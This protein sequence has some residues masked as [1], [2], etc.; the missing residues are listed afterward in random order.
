[1]QL[2]R[3]LRELWQL[4]TGVAIS[5]LLA[6][7][8]GLSSVAE[9]GL[10]PPSV[11][12]RAEEMAAASTRLLVDAP[13]SSVL[14]LSVSL[15]DVESTT[16]RA[17][18]VSNVMASAPVREYIARRAKVPAEVLEIASPV[19]PEWPRPLAQTG[20]EKHTSD[21]LA[22]TDQYRLSLASNPTVPVVEVSAQAPTA[23]AAEQLANGAVD[24]MRDY[25]RDLGAAQQVP[26]TQQVHLEQLGRAKGGVINPG[27][28]IKVALL[29]F[30]LVLAAASAAV[31]FLARVRRGWTLEADAERSA[32]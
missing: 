15:N 13:K 28:S 20:N 24:G 7:L 29:S 10:F 16:N 27:V 5:V 21:I 14:D 31:L 11:A 30:G 4:K 22:S 8:A 3:H 2:G 1:M 18:L 12:P 6:L 26:V 25:L 19:T 9:V 23:K 32:A 17:L